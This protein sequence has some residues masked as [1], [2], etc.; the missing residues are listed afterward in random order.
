MVGGNPALATFIGWVSSN[1]Y[2]P[3]RSFYYL[4]SGHSQPQ[5][6]IDLHHKMWDFEHMGIGA[7]GWRQSD[8][9]QFKMLIGIFIAFI[10]FIINMEV[11]IR[12][13]RP[14]G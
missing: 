7:R 14:F 3:E 8:F 4:Q 10:M 5:W 9:G 6:I 11:Q 13:G 2:F 1:K 12:N